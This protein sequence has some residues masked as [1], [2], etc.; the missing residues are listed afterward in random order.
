TPKAA[1]LRREAEVLR[2]TQEQVHALDAMAAN[3]QVVF[4][5]PAGTG[6]TVLAVEAARRGA[7]AGRRVLFVCFNRLLGEALR[8]Q[9]AAF[10]A[11]VVAC[12]LH[13]HMR[14]AAGLEEVE[15]PSSSFWDTELPAMAIDALLEGRGAA[16]SFDELVIDEAQD[17][18]RENYLDVLD[19][20]LRGGLAAGRWRIFGDF[21]GQNVY[22]SANISLDQFLTERAGNASRYLLTRNC[23]NTP[24]IAELASHLPGLERVYSGVLRADDYLEPTLHFYRDSAEQARLLLD[25]LERL[26]QEGFSGSD[27]VVLSARS[28]PHAIVKQVSAPPWRDRLRPLA[29]VRGGQVGYCSIHAFKGLEAPA[30]VVTDLDYPTNRAFHPLVYVAVTRARHRLTLLAS[31]SARPALACMLQRP[32]ATLSQ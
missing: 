14:L 22:D 4:E 24:R 25:A 30:V 27:I 8:E 18:L 7:A 32:M 17:I 3:A 29:E 9:T 11:N 6:K 28:D 16:F 10:G 2:F 5:G 21:I 26:Y 20:S 19:L 15:S 13:H 1:L 12:T 23:R 31:E